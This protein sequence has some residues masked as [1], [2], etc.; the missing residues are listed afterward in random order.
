MVIQT[1][2]FG[3]LMETVYALQ[4]TF[5]NS[6]S[7]IPEFLFATFEEILII[8]N[9]ICLFLPD[10]LD[11]V[12][13]QLFKCIT[14]IFES[15]YSVRFRWKVCS[16]VLAIA[17]AGHQADV[18]SCPG[19]ICPILT[20]LADPI[21][22]V[23][24]RIIFQILASI[25]ELPDDMSPDFFSKVQAMVP[26]EVIRT[27]VDIAIANADDFRLLDEALRFF[28]NLTIITSEFLEMLLSN[29]GL[30][31]LL[32]NTAA[33]GT[34]ELQ[35]SVHWLFWAMLFVATTDQ[36]KQVAPVV[37]PWVSDSFLSDDPGLLYTIVK[38]SGMVLTKSRNRGWASDRTSLDA[39]IGEIVPRL[40]DLEFSAPPELA[41]A[42]A[43][44]KR[45]NPREFEEF[46]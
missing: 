37:T 26:E 15:R 30:L 36:M 23:C 21:N 5:Q 35:K 31:P 12:I 17:T 29:A 27:C 46:T 24:F 44:I 14:E 34:P 43:A 41:R 2:L 16:L 18:V 4:A 10:R 13:N 8:L 38:A 20:F 3:F 7:E 45:A 22:S 11:G 42:I 19:V 40:S 6:E 9:S 28:T 25:F 39:L 33:N 1:P 32:Q